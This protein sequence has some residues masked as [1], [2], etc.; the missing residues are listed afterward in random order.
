[1]H[2]LPPWSTP[3]SR[4][5]QSLVKNKILAAIPAAE[6]AL[7][8]EHLTAV[9][10]QLGESLHRAGEP[11]TNV[12]FPETGFI[13]ALTMLS[14]GQPLEIGL[15]GSEGVVGNSIILGAKSSFSET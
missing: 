12:F 1:M 7:V 9:H 13:S 2:V 15:I 3:M 4:P 8:A 6:F 11:I 5:I 10:L 14:E